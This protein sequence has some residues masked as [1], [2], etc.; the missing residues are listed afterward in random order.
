[1]HFIFMLIKHLYWFLFCTRCCVTTRSHTV[2]VSR[3][4]R[5]IR[6]RPVL[7]PKFRDLSRPR[8]VPCWRLVPSYGPL[9]RRPFKDSEV[10]DKYESPKWVEN[11]E[12]R[13]YIFLWSRVLPQSLQILLIVGYVIQTD[14]ITKEIDFH[15]HCYRWIRWRLINGPKYSLLGLFTHKRWLQKDREFSNELENIQKGKNLTN[16]VNPGLNLDLVRLTQAS[17]TINYHKWYCINHL[18]FGNK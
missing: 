9:I 12:I 1:M 3:N 6:S 7:I 14:F 4:L 18:S 5:T 17:M 11:L 13:Y 15:A 10:S 16:A 8:P 2:L